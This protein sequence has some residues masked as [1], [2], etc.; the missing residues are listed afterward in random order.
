MPYVLTNTQLH[1]LKLILEFILQ[2]FEPKW[3]KV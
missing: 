3:R 1:I 2:Y